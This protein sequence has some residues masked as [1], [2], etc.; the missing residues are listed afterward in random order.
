MWSFLAPKCFVFFRRRRRKFCDFAP[1]NTLEKVVVGGTSTTRR[2]TGGVG[3]GVMVLYIWP[4]GPENPV[5]GPL[6][7]RTAG[8]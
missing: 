3:V 1:L 2:G 6:F 7:P 4:L 8:V 5:S